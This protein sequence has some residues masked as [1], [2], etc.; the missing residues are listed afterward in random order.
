MKYLHADLKDLF[1]PILP[2][3]TVESLPKGSEYVPRIS[4]KETEYY[5]S[6]YYSFDFNIS[7][8]LYSYSDSMFLTFAVPSRRNKEIRFRSIYSYY[9]LDSIG[10]HFRTEDLAYI[11]MFLNYKDS[12]STHTKKYKAMLSKYPEY[13]I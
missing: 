11:D 1:K 6:Y 4:L 9:F 2:I 7:Y 10:I 12:I 8:K 3:H 13:F 5:K